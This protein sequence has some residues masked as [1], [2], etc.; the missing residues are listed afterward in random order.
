MHMRWLE[1]KSFNMEKLGTTCGHITTSK[2]EMRTAKLVIVKHGLHKATL[3]AITGV[4]V[5]K[6]ITGVAEMTL[7]MH[8][9]SLLRW[10][11][12]WPVGL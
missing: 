5:A 12:R 8:N 2:T 10:L 3:R 4:K 1:A 7:V 6:L 9:L 11:S